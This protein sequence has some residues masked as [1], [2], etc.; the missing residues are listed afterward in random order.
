MVTSAGQSTSSFLV[1]AAGREGSQSW[2]SIQIQLKHN[3]YTNTKYETNENTV[4]IQHKYSTNVIQRNYNT[5]P[6]QRKKGRKLAMGRRVKVSRVG[7]RPP[8]NYVAPP[9][10][11]LFTY[12]HFLSSCKTS[13]KTLVEFLHKLCHTRA[14]NKC[15]I[16]GYL[17][18]WGLPLANAPPSQDYPT[19]IQKYYVTKIQQQQKIQKCKYKTTK[20]DTYI[21]RQKAMPPTARL[22]NLPSGQTDSPSL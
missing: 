2:Q 1:Q 10:K 14:H 8:T 3:S 9:S 6:I 12:F 21:G 4:E 16:W 15:T 13:V 20:E 17:A 7:P 18:G 22:F 11:A 5:N 19:K